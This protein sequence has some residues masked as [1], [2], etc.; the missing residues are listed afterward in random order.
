MYTHI[1]CWDAG[2]HDYEATIGAYHFNNS[3]NTCHGT[4][5][6]KYRSG[7]YYSSKIHML[8][9]TVNV[10]VFAFSSASISILMYIFGLIILSSGSAECLALHFLYPNI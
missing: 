9:H 6:C 8:Q 1:S 10:F 7:S 5:L 4:W 3:S 2:L